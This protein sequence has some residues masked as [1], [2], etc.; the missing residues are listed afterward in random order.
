[1]EVKERGANRAVLEID[2]DAG[3]MIHFS[4][5]THLANPKASW[6]S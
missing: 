6:N 5:L 4:G 1:M 3:M 2:G